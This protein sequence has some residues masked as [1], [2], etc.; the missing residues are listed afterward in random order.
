[1]SKADS[2]TLFTGVIVNVS[3][4]LAVRGGHG[5]AV[6]AASKA[7][8]IGE[9]LFIPMTVYPVKTARRSRHPGYRSSRSS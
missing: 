4:L 9:I 5:A 2:L 1:M 3:S 6:Y 7:G 8:L